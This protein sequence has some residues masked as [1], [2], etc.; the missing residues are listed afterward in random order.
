LNLRTSVVAATWAVLPLPLLCGA[1][2][3]PVNQD[4]PAESKTAS[5]SLK[6]ETANVEEVLATDD[7]G[8]RANTYV[9]RWHANRVLLVD[10]LASTPLVVGDDAHF[11]V[12]H[13]EVG[14]K[15]LLSFV[16]TRNQDCHCEDGQQRKLPAKDADPAS[17]SGG[18]DFKS[19]IVEEVLGAEDRGYRAIGYIVQ[20]QGKRI[21]V[22]DPIAQSQYGIGD[23]ISFLALRSQ[24]KGSSLL[25]FTAMPANFAGAKPAP[26]ATLG[27]TPAAQVVTTPQSGVIAEVL[28]ASDA[29]YRY[30]AYVVEAL[31]ARIVIEDSSGAAPHQVGEQLAF[32]S[33]RMPSPLSPGHGLLRFNLTAKPDGADMDIEGAHVSLHTDTATVDEVLT[34][35]VIGDRYVAYIVK[36]NSARVA[37]SDVFASTHY[38]VGDRIT[39]PVSRAGTAGQGHLDFMMF[40]FINPSPLSPR[41]TASNSGEKPN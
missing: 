7:D 5:P 30:R 29:N 19:G 36:W 40:N 41:G 22:A 35:D 8:F 39:F 23:T 27:G 20:S 10:P 2:Q 13:H 3:T 34:T 18:A 37:V 11:L 14:G 21:A 24:V 1:Q 4:R 16:F 33:R 38:A 26:L 28:T 6:V 12:T 31:G 25:A 9:V 15:R 32:I 17:V